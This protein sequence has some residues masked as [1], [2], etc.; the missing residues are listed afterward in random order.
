MERINKNKVTIY[1]DMDLIK[2]IKKEMGKQKRS[3]NNLL[4]FIISS[5]F[6]KSGD[7]KNVSKA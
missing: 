7:I 6:D 2:R 1:P 5:Y 3:L 4:L